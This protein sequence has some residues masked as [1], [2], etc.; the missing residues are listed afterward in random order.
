LKAELTGELGV[1]FTT[2]TS[3]PAF[4]E[5]QFTIAAADNYTEYL[6]LFDQYRI[7]MIEVWIDPVA[8]QGSTVF[9]TVATC[10][11]LDDANAPSSLAQVSCHQ[12]SLVANGGVSRYHC[13]KPHAAI[14]AYS[15][16]F[17]SF[18]NE[19]SPW[20]DSG[21][22]SIQHY[23][24]KY[25]ALPTPASVAYRGLFKLHCTFRAPGV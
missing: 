8:A 18:V 4:G 13:W 11:D 25:A 21:S 9:S 14:A 19:P 7:D 20:C 23:G 22:I 5:N 24:L 12:G 17:T 2:S 10:V 1:I 16:T 3:V 15:G 6:A